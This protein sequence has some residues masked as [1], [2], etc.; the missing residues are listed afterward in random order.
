[1]T[2]FTAL[3]VQLGAEFARRTVQELLAVT[4]AADKSGSGLSAKTIEL[5]LKILERILREMSSKFTDFTQS[6]LSWVASPA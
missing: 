3:S 4:S 1:M 6:I 5:L 2:L